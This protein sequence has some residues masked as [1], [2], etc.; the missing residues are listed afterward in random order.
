M[1][2]TF[3][4]NHDSACAARVT[5]VV[6][7][8]SATIL[9]LQAIYEAAYERYEHLQCYKGTKINWRFC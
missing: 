3:L 1:E 6:L 8:V 2:Y 9:G 4:S 7:C 5:V